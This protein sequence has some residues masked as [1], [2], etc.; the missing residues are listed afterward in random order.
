M[1]LQIILIIQFITNVQSYQCIFEPQPEHSAYDFEDNSIWTSSIEGALCPCHK[2]PVFGGNCELIIRNVSKTITFTNVQ[3]SIPSLKLNNNLLVTVEYNDLYIDQFEGGNVTFKPSIKSTTIN[4]DTLLLDEDY[5]GFKITGN[6]YIRIFEILKSTINNKLFLGTGF[7]G[8]IYMSNAFIELLNGPLHITYDF[9][10]F[11]DTSEYSYIENSTIM[12]KSYQFITKSNKY[13]DLLLKNV[14][15]QFVINS[16]PTFV[17]THS[18]VILE[19][20]SLI[21]TYKGHDQCVDEKFTFATSD[22]GSVLFERD[23]LEVVIEPQIKYRFETS[24]KKLAF[25]LYTQNCPYDIY[26]S[27]TVMTI[28]ASVIIGSIFFALTLVITYFI[29]VSMARTVSQKY[30]ENLT[31]EVLNEHDGNSSEL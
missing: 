5:N 2:Y 3:G 24:S 31:M 27:Q 29:F 10:T 11:E 23:K 7:I 17:T 6:Y 13:I 9:F 26:K 16:S 14:V 20:L 28:L 12:F 4:I 21:G 8:K 19:N 18:I 30:I 1:I 22:V 25:W 15:I